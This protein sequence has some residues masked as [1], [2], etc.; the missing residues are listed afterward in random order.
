MAHVIVIP[1]SFKGALTSHEACAAISDGLRRAIPNI[2]VTQIPVADGGE[3]TVDAM[4]AAAG[5]TRRSA[6]VCGVFP[7][8]RIT[9]EYGLID[10]GQTAIVEMA[11]CAGLP[12]AHGREDTKAATTRGVGELI[13]HAVEAGSRDIIVGA[14][15][16]ATTDL[17]C[18]A[19]TALGVRFFDEKG[20]EF[21]PVGGTLSSVSSIDAGAAES[22]L[23][24]VTLTV[25]CDINN[26]LVGPNGAAHIFGPQKGADSQEVRVLDEG[27]SHV[28][29]IISRDLGIDVRDVPGAGAAGGLAGGL[30]A[31]FGAELRPGID[32]VLE[33]VNFTSLIAD[34][35]LV[36]TGEGQID[37]Q[38]LSGKVPIGVARW[39]AAHRP[40]LPVVVLAGSIGGDIG[41]VY[42][43]GITSVF[44][45]GRRPEPL[46]EAIAA[47]G[48]NLAAAAR[49]V[50]RLFDAARG[51][52]GRQS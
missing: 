49:D 20:E 43:E 16:S 40:E 10:D 34:A 18:G 1:D 24:G 41:D 31:F 23:N 6:E 17:G 27:L 8:E 7:G 13:R 11:A 15:G 36:I 25:M 46:A 29:D 37:G 22:L 51:L 12:L 2:A 48:E 3:G 52:T 30:L 44:P 38:S 35:D 26:P 45:I 50:V 19:A 5:G 14:G 32:I 21:V 28:A 47:T 33:T 39:V 4:V 42:A 9:A